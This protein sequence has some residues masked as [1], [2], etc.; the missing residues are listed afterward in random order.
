MLGVEEPIPLFVVV[1][2]VEGTLGELD[3]KVKLNE[4]GPNTK[5]LVPVVVPVEKG[6]LGAAL[7]EEVL[8]WSPENGKEGAEVLAPLLTNEGRVGA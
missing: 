7:V 3:P 1:T 8:S 5:G 6:W 4:V 2:G